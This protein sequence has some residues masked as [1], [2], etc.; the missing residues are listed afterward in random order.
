MITLVHLEWTKFQQ[1][2]IGI[3]GLVLDLSTQFTVTSVNLYV[4]ACAYPLV[5]Q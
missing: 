5:F 4:T 3:Q 2:A 1:T